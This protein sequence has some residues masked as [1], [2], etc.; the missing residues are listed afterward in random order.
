MS[1]QWSRGSPRLCKMRELAGYFQWHCPGWSSEVK[2]RSWHRSGSH[3]AKSFR[4]RDKTARSSAGRGGFSYPAVAP[5]CSD[6][7]SRLFITQV[8]AEGWWL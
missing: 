6:P 4:V 7:I 8:V 3:K 1:V 2:Q 5:I